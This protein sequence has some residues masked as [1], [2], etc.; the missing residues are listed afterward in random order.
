MPALESEFDLPYDWRPRPYQMPAWE[1]LEKGC[2]RVDLV[3]HRRAGKDLF[4]FNWGAR[5]SQVRVGA[6]WHALPN[7]A[8]GRKIVWDGMTSGG[9]PFLDYIPKALI[10]RVRNDE[11]KIWLKNGSTFQVVGAD[12]PSTLVGTNP[13]G[14]TFSEYSI[15]NPA[16]WEFVRPILSE[17]GG[18]ALFLYT[19]RG[20]NW[21]YRLHQQA[22]ENPTW[23]SQ[24]LTVDDTHAI[25]MS[26]IEE[27]RASGMPEAMVQ[28]EYYCSFNSAL[29]GSYYGGHLE[30]AQKSG[31]IAKVPWE[32]SL[33]VDTGWDLGTNN[34]T[35]IW[36]KQQV[37]AER[38]IID[39]YMNAST[40][41]EHY[42]KKLHEKPYSYGKHFFPHDV[43]VTE[44]QSNKS[45]I[46]VLRQLGVRPTVVPKSSVDDGIQAVWQYL[47]TC[48]F[49]EKA[50][51]TGLTGLGEYVKQERPGQEG[52]KGEPFY[53]EDP[54][55]TWASDVADAFRTLVMGDRIGR[56]AGMD[57]GLTGDAQKRSFAPRVAVV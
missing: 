25:P 36:F 11:M 55:H 9:R 49:D 37:R 6:Y 1:A 32:P 40:S 5:S 41:L 16:L 39:F 44:L 54:K 20:R 13:V 47:P 19:P 22:Q 33:P 34:F 12:D 50:C 56:Y 42:V 45:R 29:I 52:P 4:A 30:A 8:Q 17:N 10:E 43:K 28:Q 48:Y 57:S 7:Y 51:E 3:W 21:G 31:R 18:W 38:R 53:T 27:D 26:A 2:K 24:R 35:C 46:H 14:V 23:F 15:Q